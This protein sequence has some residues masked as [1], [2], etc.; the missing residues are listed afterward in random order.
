[1]AGK[2][3]PPNNGI[4]PPFLS[5]RPADGTS[6]SLNASAA[7]KK[8]MPDGKPNAGS[9]KGKLPAEVAGVNAKR[10]SQGAKG[11]PAFMRKGK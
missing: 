9:P 10:K 4:K 3:P 2:K 1:M 6:P 8:T 5:K 11:L 7:K